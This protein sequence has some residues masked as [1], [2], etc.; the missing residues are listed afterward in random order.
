MKKTSK[1]AGKRLHQMK[2]IDAT[3]INVYQTAPM[4]MLE[5][6]MRPTKTSTKKK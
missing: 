2:N 3:Q 5:G 1:T 4:S 6:V